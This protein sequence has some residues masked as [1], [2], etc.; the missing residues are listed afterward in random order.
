MLFLAHPVAPVYSLI[1]HSRNPPRIEDRY[2][3]RCGRVSIILPSKRLMGPIEAPGEA[4]SRI[5]SH[6]TFRGKYYILDT[7]FNI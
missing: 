3:I 4:Q 6:D 2:I 5:G 7:H 1:F